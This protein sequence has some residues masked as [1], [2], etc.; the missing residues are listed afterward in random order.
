MNVNRDKKII[1]EIM[2]QFLKITI[3]KE[4]KS[5]PHLKRQYSRR[6][7]LQQPSRTDYTN[8]IQCTL[9]FIKKSFYNINLMKTQSVIK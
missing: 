1:S 5:E 7:L 4:K 3:E 2:I 8:Q 6:H 9:I